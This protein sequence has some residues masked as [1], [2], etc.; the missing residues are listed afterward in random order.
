MLKDA[1]VEWLTRPVPA[2]NIAVLS[3]EIEVS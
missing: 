2:D 1:P 3:I